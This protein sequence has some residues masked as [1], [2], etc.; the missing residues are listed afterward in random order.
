M[1][2]P[3]SGWFGDSGAAPRGR[4][5]SDAGRTEAP[6]SRIGGGAPRQQGPNPLV[7]GRITWGTTH[8]SA[9]ANPGNPAARPN[10]SG[11]PPQT[12]RMPENGHPGASG[13]GIG[14][15]P[16]GG[17]VPDFDRTAV[18]P[19]TGPGSGVV[20]DFDR[21]AVLP[22][23]GPGGGVVPDFDR[24]AVLPPTGPG[25]GVVPDFDR[26]AV[27]PPTGAGAPMG[28]TRA[29]PASGAGAG[30]G[31]GSGPAPVLPSGPATAALRDPW[32]ET[33]DTDGDA[34]AAAGHTHDPH[35]VT[36]QLDAVHLG[37][38]VLLRADGGHRKSGPE[39]SDGPVFVDASG[40][41]SR[42]YR[43]LGIL[44]A[45]ACA[46]YAVVIVSTLLSGNSDAP[47]M[48][49]PGQEEGAPAGQV[50]TTP[51]PSQSAQ[52]SDT[53]PAAPQATPSAGVGAT[54]EPGVD[55]PAS[56]TSGVTGGATGQPGTSV[57]PQS[58]APGTDQNPGGGG[59]TGPNP[60][61]STQV[62]PSDTTDP[63]SPTGGGDTGVDPTE[64]T[65]GS[66]TGTDPGADGTNANGAGDPDPL[67]GQNGTPVVVAGPADTSTSP[68]LSPEN[69]L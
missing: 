12:P 14:T 32:Q 27:L 37:D 58:S 52:P 23:T 63:S 65:G 61:Q 54:T 68:H 8:A 21:T 59:A 31:A 41:R 62:P 50:D 30:A 47:W 13:P 48:P 22:P 7:R 39:P 66:T 6:D 64:P 44:V 55:A 60:T 38:G 4:E 40:R 26:T 20:P 46:V 2:A 53:G 49:A 35:E 9:G 42:L 11:T 16:G 34:G 51:A 19:P 43:R 45:V 25:G 69:T 24:T 17:V 28:A 56:G 29:F 3:G 10:P 15:G 33:P 5:S 67:A 57:G 18:L 1:S 36:V